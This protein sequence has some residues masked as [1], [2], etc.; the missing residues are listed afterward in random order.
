MR[1]ATHIDPS[2][3]P[4]SLPSAEDVRPP[5]RPKFVLNL[6]HL[7]VLG[8]E[9]RPSLIAAVSDGHES[10]VTENGHPVASI[11]D[12]PASAGAP[13]GPGPRRTARRSDD[14]SGRSRP[15]PCGRP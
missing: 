7:E 3:G 11:R 5:N 10:V 8:D 15:P 1:E 6:P 14:R 2:V 9:C 12:E 4:R 13:N